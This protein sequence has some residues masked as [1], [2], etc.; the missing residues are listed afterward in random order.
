L[1]ANRN[2]A[3][4]AAAPYFD[5]AMIEL[6]K[7]PQEPGWMHPKEEAALIFCRYPQWSDQ[8]VISLA[9]M[10]AYNKDLKRLKEA[11]TLIESRGIKHDSSLLAR[12]YK[13]LKGET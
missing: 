12:Y 3:W 4:A 8:L 1:L 5:K 13:I 10:A 2:G 6:H 9:D 7:S 11:V